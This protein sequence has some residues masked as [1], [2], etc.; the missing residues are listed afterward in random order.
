MKALLREAMRALDEA[1][2]LAVVRRF[3]AD[4]PERAA[5]SAELL[6]RIVAERPRHVRIDHRMG[7]V[8]Q[9]VVRR[10]AAT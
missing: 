7:C 4:A 10:R 1:D 6:C 9:A 5:A 3:R 2:L 8:E